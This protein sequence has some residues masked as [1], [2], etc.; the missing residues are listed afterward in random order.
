MQ[1]INASTQNNDYVILF[2]PVLVPRSAIQSPSLMS[3]PAPAQLLPQSSPQPTLLPPPPV[4]IEAP[5]Q[6]ELPAIQPT[7][8]NTPQQKQ[9]NNGLAS[10]KQMEWVH[11]IA[12]Q[13]GMTE[14]EICQTMG[15]ES[16]DQLTKNQAS[17]FINKYKKD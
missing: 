11:N 15:V 13:R 10:D 8:I 6:D 4:L 14:A 5:T 1:D 9:R 2:Q 17:A 3:L 7:A 16:L 12:R